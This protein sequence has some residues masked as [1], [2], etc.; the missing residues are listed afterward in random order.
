[1]E[2]TY[3][4]FS[5][6]NGVC[7]SYSLGSDNLS[8]YSLSLAGVNGKFLVSLFEACNP[9]SLRGLQARV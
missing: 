5:G 9:Y 3:Q 1:M 6:K 8:I 7:L 2:V 4:Y